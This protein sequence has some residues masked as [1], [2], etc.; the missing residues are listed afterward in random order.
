MASLIPLGR[1][2]GRRAQQDIDVLG[3]QDAQDRVDDRR[4]ADPRSAGDDGDLR[5]ERRA[6][7]IG[8]AGRQGDPGLPLHPGQGLVRIDVGPWEIAGRDP[9]QI[10]GDRAFGPVQP[11]EEY[12]GRILHG[13]G[14]HRAFGQLQVQRG[15]DQ[16]AG[17]LQEF[18]RERPEFLFRQAAMT[19]VHRFGQRIADAR[20]DPDHGRLLDSELHCDGVGGHETDAAD[21]AC[22]GGTGS[23]SSPPRHRRRRS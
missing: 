14:N 2:P 16:L 15:A 20:A 1:A 12:A 5:G 9:E 8:L 17:N 11:P 23:P 6:H 4:L 18:G 10:S 7:R 13:V 3:G 21:V 19:L 22:R